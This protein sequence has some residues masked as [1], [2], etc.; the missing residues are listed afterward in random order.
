MKREAKTE[1]TV[2]TWKPSA[3]D[4]RIAVC[5]LVCLL[6]SNALTALDL[7][8]AV[9]EM[10][11][12][13]IQKATACISCLLCCQ[14]TSDA[15]RRAGAMRVLVTA[16]GAVCGMAV[17]AIDQLTGSNPW[18][19]A[20]LMTVGLVATL[21]LCRM[22]GAPAFNA[23]IGAISFLLV[24]STLTGTARLWYAVFRLISTIFGALVT[25]AVTSLMS[26]GQV[27]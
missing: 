10:R 18:L 13:V 2:E 6:A 16:V 27:V 8:F 7:R 9:G 17:V 19:L 5:V 25:W 1:S 11:L 3:L 26:R 15:S 20:M 23:R 14:D 24:A 22:A 21:C 4:A 12:D